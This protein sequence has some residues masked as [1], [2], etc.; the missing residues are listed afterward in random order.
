[1]TVQKEIIQ[2]WLC[3]NGYADL[4]GHIATSVFC[5][6]VYF[7]DGKAQYAGLT[8]RQTFSNAGTAYA[9]CIFSCRRL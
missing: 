5:G 6:G 3:C 2:Q 8:A 9:Q 7:I 1:M 4:G